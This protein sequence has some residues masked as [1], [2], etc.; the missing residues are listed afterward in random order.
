M[1][2][3]KVDVTA[4]TPMLATGRADA[5][6]QFIT[7]VDVSVG[8]LREAGKTVKVIPW[9]EYGI[10]G[11]ATSILASNK[12]LATRRG[13]VV[14]FAKAF[15]QAE[16]MMRA[17]PAKAAAAVK[18]E[19]P[20]IDLALAESMAKVTAPLLFGPNTMRDGLGVFDPK[21]V[22]TTW[23]WVAKQVKS[24]PAK[25]DWNAAVDYKIAKGE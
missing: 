12:M 10:A 19:V 9:K 16:E 24:P 21:L 5:I 17:D 14:K 13:D 3:L 18:A 25:F 15:K 4:M 2:L 11:Y 20:E 6:I 7:N 8:P 22:E 23:Q 1:N